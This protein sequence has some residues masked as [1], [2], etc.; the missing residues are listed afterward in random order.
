MTPSA[1]V[2]SYFC[3]ELLSGHRLQGVSL[4]IVRDSLRMSVH[5]VKI[6][7][8][9]TYLVPEYISSTSY[10]PGNLLRSVNQVEVCAW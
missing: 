4:C 10:Q 2:R 6:E 9:K 8:K 7:K 1:V 5:L 3:G